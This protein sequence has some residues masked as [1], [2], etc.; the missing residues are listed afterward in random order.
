MKI[1][2]VLLIIGILFSYVPMIPMDDC[3]EGD[4]TGNMKMDC[5]NCPLCSILISIDGPGHYSLPLT[6][7]LNVPPSLSEVDE[8][9]FP[10]FHPPKSLI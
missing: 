10:I 6:G 5:G 1:I 7:R 4:H 9:S 2:G 8:L 3:Q